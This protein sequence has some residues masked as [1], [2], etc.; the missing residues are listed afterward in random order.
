MSAMFLALPE[1]P[2]LQHH[3]KAC[4]PPPHLVPTQSQSEATFLVSSGHSDTLLVDISLSRWSVGLLKLRACP[5][6]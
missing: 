1:L 2:L 3:P 6:T 5:I 4:L